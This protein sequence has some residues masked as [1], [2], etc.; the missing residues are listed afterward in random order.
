MAREKQPS[1]FTWA[2]TKKKG[3][4]YHVLWKAGKAILK[5]YQKDQN[6]QRVSCHILLTQ[7]MHLQKISLEWKKPSILTEHNQF[8]QTFRQSSPVS[9]FYDNLPNLQASSHNTCIFSSADC[10]ALHKGG[11]EHH[12]HFTNRNMRVP[13]DEITCPR[14]S[15]WASDQARNRI[16]SSECQDSALF[17]GSQ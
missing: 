6:T 8:S 1:I 12:H 17:I 11:K 4:L 2:T 15:R 3:F 9:I 13:I 14:L 10:K 16:R 5:I 7:K